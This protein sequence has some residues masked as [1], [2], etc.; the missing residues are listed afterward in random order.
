[1]SSMTIQE[2][3]EKLN[4]KE[5][6]ESDNSLFYNYYIYQY[7]ATKEYEM[8]AQLQDFKKNLVRPTSY[9]DVVMLDIFDTFCEY[10]ESQPFGKKFRSKLHYILEKDMEDEKA[11]GV[12]TM[13]TDNA[14]RREFMQFVHDKIVRLSQEN[15]HL[16]HPYVFVYGIGK[17]YPY[18]RCNEFLTAYEEFNDTSLYKIILFYPG[19]RDG[20]SYVLFDMLHDEHSYRAILLVNE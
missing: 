2:L 11:K 17:I 3:Y 20:N 15:T 5:F 12:V 14:H 19:H 13:L 4:S 1:M 10:L 7:P 6:Q 9:V 16:T 8:R 18:L